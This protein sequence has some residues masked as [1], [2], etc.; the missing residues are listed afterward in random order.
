MK[1]ELRIYGV[2]YYF[3]QP[4]T[5][6]NDYS[7]Q[8][9]DNED[10]AN[11]SDND[12]IQWAEDNGDVHSLHGFLRELEAHNFGAKSTVPKENMQHRA[13]LVDTENPMVTPVRIDID[14]IKMRVEDIGYS[15]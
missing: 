5:E 9:Y 11:L 15:L 7:F 13:Y 14:E 3:T 10:I 8:E 2:S 1:A 4:N 6:N 12:F